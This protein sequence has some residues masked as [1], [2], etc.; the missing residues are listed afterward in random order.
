MILGQLLE[1]IL[2]IQLEGKATG[3]STTTVPDSTLTGIY[4]DDA[5][6]GGL[7][8][9]HTTTDALAPQSQ[10]QAISAYADATGTFTVDTVFTA[11]VGSGDFYSV[12]DPQY[13]KVSVLRVVNDALRAFGIISLTN[14]SL[15]TL[16]DT[17]EYTLALAIKSFP[18]DRVELGNTT[19]GFSE[20]TDYYILPALPGTQAK[21][22]FNSQLP[23]DETT[24]TNYTLRIWY[25]DY[26]PTVD[27][28][29]DYI[30]E[31]IPEKR[32]IDECKLALHEYMMEKNSDMSEE[33]RIKLGMLTQKQG[34]SKV[35][36]RINVPNR[37]ISKF[38]NIRDY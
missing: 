12:A 24:P 29:D 38:L 2:P 31:T 1:K 25:R 35:E 32:A 10:F 33:A 13:K 6:K 28:Y 26:H 16:P 4:D 5:F 8:F 36:N 30:S 7:M 21:I 20:L 19:D 3:G 11:A 22:V 9:I 17:L 37:R 23:Y 27:T 14:T 18:L 15:T 34:L